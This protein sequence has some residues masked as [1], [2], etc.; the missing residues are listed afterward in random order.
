[1][2][3]LR[4]LLTA[5]LMTAALGIQS[6]SA[7]SIDNTT[8]TKSD[9]SSKFEDPDDTIPFPHIGDDGQPTNNFQAQPVGNTGMSFS[10]TPSNA[11][12]DAFQRAQDRMQQ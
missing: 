9:G 2:Q 10:L 3:S 6:A 1:M 5:M 7:L 8:A 4:F 12:P 11:E